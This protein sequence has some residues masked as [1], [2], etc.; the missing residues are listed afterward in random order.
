VGKILENPE[1][2]Q[3][4]KGLSANLQKIANLPPPP[5]RRL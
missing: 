1:E 4:K 2:K 5:F 3:R